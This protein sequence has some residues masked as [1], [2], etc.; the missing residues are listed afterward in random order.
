MFRKSAVS[1]LLVSLIACNSGDSTDSMESDTEATGASHILGSIVISETG[2]TLY[3]QAIDNLEGPFDNT[4]AIEIAGNSLL[5]VQDGAVLVGLNEEPIW[6]KYEEQNG[7]LVETGRLSLAAYGWPNIDYG[8]VFVRNDLA[9][10]LSSGL[11]T[12]IRW[13]PETM[14]IL[15]EFDISDVAEDGYGVELSETVSHDG[16]VYINARHVDW[17]QMDVLH[18]TKLVIVDP[19]AGAVEDVI[20][21][22]RCPVGGRIFFDDAGN[23]YVMSDGRNYTIQAVARATGSENVP[24][25]CFLKLPAGADAFDP[26]WKVDV[27]ALT[28]GREVVTSTEWATIDQGVSFAKVM[29][30]E[31]LP[32]GME[33]TSFDFWGVPMA[34]MWA[35]DMNTEP[36]TASEVAGIPFSGIGFP[37]V[38]YDGALLTGETTDGSFSEIF[39]IDPVSSEATKMFEM[40]GYFY[41]LFE[42]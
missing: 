2:R 22:D 10:S 18:Q 24:K 11:E 7:Q 21:D 29:Y 6:I 40:D 31:E 5:H 41:G 26:D 20:T 27:E 15:G 4:N 1:A 17:E 8:N 33:P 3:V 32:E 39:A 12:A 9:L 16:L 35:F 23:G 38:P 34:K 30:E 37:G 28:G 42:L 36:P 13:D 19:D 14:T 25:N